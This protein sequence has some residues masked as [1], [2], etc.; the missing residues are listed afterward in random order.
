MKN[1]ASIRQH[2]F[3]IKNRQIMYVLLLTLAIWCAGAIAIAADKIHWYEVEKGFTESKRAN[4]FVL[5][6]IYTDWC[7]PCHLMDQNTFSDQ[8]LIEFL[9]HKFICVKANAEDKGPG[10]K[11]VKD[12]SVQGFPCALVFD[13]KGKLVGRILGFRNA[14]QY[15][16]E[17][18]DILNAS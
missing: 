5:V 12:Y 15:Q 6:D 4:K 18:E 17:L 10:R 8:D 11:L 9:D 2:V 16:A 14:Q 3:P 7:G 13:L 1:P